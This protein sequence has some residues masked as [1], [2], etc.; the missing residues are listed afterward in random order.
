[1]NSKAELRKWLAE[2]EAA[3]P[4][5][6]CFVAKGKGK[7]SGNKPKQGQDNGHHATTKL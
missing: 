4:K 6:G 7:K 2:V 1:M 5:N 3:E